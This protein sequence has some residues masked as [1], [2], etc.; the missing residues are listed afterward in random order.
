MKN[1][2]FLTLIIPK[3]CDRITIIDFPTFV[4]IHKHSQ[5]HRFFKIKF[6]HT[7]TPYDRY[8]YYSS[9]RSIHNKSYARNIN[10]Y[11][12]VDWRVS[13]SSNFLQTEIIYRRSV[14]GAV[15]PTNDGREV[16]SD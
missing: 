2:F 13:D 10:T 15:A 12:Y 1:Y 9:I 6:Y 5:T 14:K 4:K 3:S 7:R 11:Y 8:D 16:C